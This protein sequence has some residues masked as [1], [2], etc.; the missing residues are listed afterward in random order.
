[1]QK[2]FRTA[3][4]ATAAILCG[5]A[6]A[7]DAGVAAAQ[8]TEYVMKD[9]EKPFSSDVAWKDNAAIPAGAQT[10]LI[11]GDPKK[12]GPYIFRVKLPAGYKLPAH[13]H[14]DTRT[15]TVLQ[16]SYWSGVGEKFDQSKL[17]K[18]T[19]GS[20]YTTE[21]NVPHFS[22]AETDVIIQEMGQGPVSNP[23][24]YVDA[25]QDPRKK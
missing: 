9:Y 22:W 8:A 10:V 24:E 13:K 6:L 21:A 11:F 5:A 23:I 2:Q 18:F 1:M 25:S 17:Q 16:G 15:V 3:M 19:W 7:L 14:T 20:F 12:E 4:V